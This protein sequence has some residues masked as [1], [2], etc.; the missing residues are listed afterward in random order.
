[1]SCVFCDVVAGDLEAEVVFDDEA[2]LAFLDHRPVQKGHI[3]M[4]PRQH[5]ETLLD[6]P[7]DL[8]GRFVADGQRLAAAVVEGLGAQGSFVAVNNVV[9]QS[10][11]HLHLHVVPR[12]RGDGLKGFFWPRHKYAAGEQREYADRLRAVL[13]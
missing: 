13:G 6:L 7:P 12:S 3:L 11:P 9:S 4:V 1:M 10:V 5:L 2:F 8:H